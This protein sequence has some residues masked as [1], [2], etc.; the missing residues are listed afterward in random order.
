MASF[1]SSFVN[2]NS[3]LSLYTI[4]VVW[5]T[6]FYPHTLKFM[7]IDKLIGYNNT[8]PRSS[9]A[10]SATGKVPQATQ[11]RLARMEGAHANGNEAMPLWFA[12][13]LA[14]NLA[15]L[16]THWLNVMALSYVATRVAY[17]T[18]YIYYNDVAGG[19]I[20]SF[21]YFFGLSF[22]LRILFKA[23]SQYAAQHA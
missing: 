10:K 7:T 8:L 15:G 20:R 17:N 13:V 2:L 9:D 23:A 5:F 6:G 14:G 3:P 1:L 16:D 22:P 19:W 12:A 11:L 18:T 4:P 21:F